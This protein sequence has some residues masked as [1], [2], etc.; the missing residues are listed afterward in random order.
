MIPL[1][2]DI[3]TR[4]ASDLMKSG[5][6]A[7]AEHPT[8]EI[9]IA[10]WALGD[11]VVRT[12]FP[13]ISTRAGSPMP[14]ALADALRDDSVLVTAH[15][16]AFERLIT[17]GAPGR[18]IGFPRLAAAR[19]DCTAARAARV[20]LPRSLG[21][22]AEALGLAHQKDPAGYA[23]MRRMCRPRKPKQGEPTDRL[24]WLDDDE[25]MAREGQYCAQ[26]VQ[27]ER[28]IGEAVPPLSADER[29]TYL[30]TEA[31]NDAGVAVDFDLLL[32]VSCLLADA[33]RGLL[34]DLHRI[35]GQRIQ[36]LHHSYITKWLASRGYDDLAEDG[37]GKA[38]VAAMLERDDLDPVVR[39]VMT[40]RRDGGGTAAKKYA[41]LL[42]RLSGDGRLRGS[43]VYCGAPS[44]GRWS[45]RGVQLQ[46]LVRM[47]RLKKPARL[48]AC[49]RDVTGGATAAEVAEL[50]GPPVVIAGELLRPTLTATATTW[51]ARGDSKQIEAR[52]APW[53]AGAEWK[54]D[55]F[56]AFDAGTGPDLYKVAAAGIYRITPDEIADDDPRRQIGKV[57]E[58]ALGFQGGAGALQ[59]M[60]QAYGIKIPRHTPT[61]EGD[62]PAAGTDEWIKTQW[63]A[64]NPEF[65]A[66]NTGMWARLEQGALDCV[67]GPPGPWHQVGRLAFRRNKQCM[68]L[69]L[70]SGGCL[71]YWTPRVVARYTP[72]SEQRRTVVYRAEDAATGR[73]AEFAA[74]GGLWFENA[75]QATARE[76]MAYWLRRLHR[77]PGCR[78]VLTVHDE[79]VCEMDRAAYP[80]P[81]HAA[82][83]VEREMKTAPE[84]ADGLPVNADSS[85]GARYVKG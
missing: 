2:L 49:I 22:A 74:Y 51:L 60:A 62:P 55:R 10:A 79:G 71:V 21:G 44:T 15:N 13:P 57:S 43:L 23:L 64:N 56:R 80:L 70:P 53:L 9:T 12:W 28:A 37:V 16:A 31:M 6:Y 58:L 30:V 38:A 5:V 46:N 11:D 54:L 25:S 85:A 32:A 4:S 41:A 67:S 77:L 18:R 20:G 19:F 83:A 72:W 65:A 42:A 82:A 69:R 47:S 7:Y 52:V 76:L 66:R 48:D 59:N 39:Q 81:E 45:S 50:Y 29:E 3:E 36:G 34:A 27:V 17:G 35:T 73:W 24:L 33:E 14:A 75:V 61:L 84:W 1:H 63:R 8:T 26:D 68:V 40:L 78:P